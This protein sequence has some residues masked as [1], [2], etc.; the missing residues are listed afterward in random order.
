LLLS[1]HMNLLAQPLL[2]PSLPFVVMTGAAIGGYLLTL[3][4]P[5]VANQAIHFSLLP[6]AMGPLLLYMQPLQGLIGVVVA[7]L[8]LL[9]V[10]RARGEVVKGAFNL[11]KNLLTVAVVALEI[12]TLGHGLNLSGPGAVLL[13]VL[14]QVTVVLLSYVLVNG[15]ISIYSRSWNLR[16]GGGMALFMQE[17]A[18]YGLGAVVMFLAANQPLA[19][20]PLGIPLAWLIVLQ[21][22][23]LAQDAE[24]SRLVQLHEIV[25]MLLTGQ[26]LT[27]SM[28]QYVRRASRLLSS[29]FVEL[30]ILGRDAQAS[31]RTG[32]QNSPLLSG[33]FMV[34]LAKG[35]E[36]S[37]SGITGF[38]AAQRGFLARMRSLDSVVL[39]PDGDGEV[40]ALF[41]DYS[42]SEGFAVRLGNSSDMLGVLIVGNGAGVSR[43]DTGRLMLG[44]NLGMQTAVALERSE[45][46]GQV[47]GSV[48]ERERL[49]TRALSDSL[50]GLGNR[51]LFTERL[52]EAILELG[53]RPGTLGLLYLDLD[54][55]K[56]VNDAHGHRCGDL[57][58]GVV[59]R[60]LKTTI[61][62]GDVVA[63]LGGDEFGVLLSAIDGE[64][65]ALEVADRIVAAL[66]EPISV[67]TATV[68]IG[69][70][71]GVAT[72]QDP[73]C[74]MV[75]L[76]EEAD[77][78]MYEAKH[79]GRNQ[80]RVAG[81]TRPRLAIGA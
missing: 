80:V 74:G 55:F 15:V 78:A 26:D 9:A 27:Q 25:E 56:A 71:I 33:G 13:C 77:Q 32:E 11:G 50:T 1:L 67:K 65:A 19:I 29:D 18:I 34:R 36:L 66:S 58:L 44:R 38:S 59:A 60:R 3:N 57:V 76:V 43:S 7:D 14:V 53:T 51:D 64:A 69:V 45:L 61:R 24:N 10:T 52:G 46:L 22:R 28:D 40:A 17:I 5:L 2:Q 16:Y 20:L 12:Q 68:S 42:L 4:R 47:R 62:P 63:R 21:N 73:G 37:R 30:I 54:G 8:A 81:R 49:R 39:S 79:A 41:E 35:S 48:V 23:F 6:F 31:R 75:E 70:C 72:S